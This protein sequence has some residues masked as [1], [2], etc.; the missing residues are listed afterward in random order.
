[1]IEKKETKT[2]RCR[3]CG[4]EWQALVP[5]PKVCPRCKSHYW[6]RPPR[7]AKPSQSE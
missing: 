1:M 7:R 2:C 4:Y 6:D 3:Y 5:Q